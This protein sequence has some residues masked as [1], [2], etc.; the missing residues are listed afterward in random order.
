VIITDPHVSNTSGYLV[1]ENGLTLQANSGP[2]PN[3][4]SIYVRKPD[5]VST[6]VGNCWPGPSVWIDYLNTNA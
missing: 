2:A 3:I 1:Y 4:T 6:F 5:G